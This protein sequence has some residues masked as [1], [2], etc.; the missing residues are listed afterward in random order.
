MIEI[1]PNGYKRVYDIKSINKKN[2]QAVE[3][4]KR[5]MYYVTIS[6]KERDTKVDVITPLAKYTD[7]NC[8]KQN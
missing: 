3:D 8:K 1:Y 5:G 4:S 6:F 2:I 7:S